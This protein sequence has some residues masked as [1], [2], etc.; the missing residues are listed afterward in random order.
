MI[1]PDPEVKTPKDVKETE[2]PTTTKASVSS[3]ISRISFKKKVKREDEFPDSTSDK[4]SST[5]SADS[6]ISDFDENTKLVGDGLPNRTESRETKRKSSRK[7]KTNENS[8]PTKANNFLS[9]LIGAGA[10]EVPPK[11]PFKAGNQGR[12]GHSGQQMKPSLSN[13]GGVWSKMPDLPGMSTGVSNILTTW[14]VAAPSPDI[15]TK[16][17]QFFCKLHIFYS[18]IVHVDFYTYIPT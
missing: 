12:E 3:E 18:K 17:K 5:D 1:S 9:K 16:G 7:A 15:S 2:T 13:S 6:D 4:S 10:D 14:G 8:V 11:P